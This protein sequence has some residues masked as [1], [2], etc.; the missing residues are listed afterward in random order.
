MPNLKNRSPEV[1]GDF[2]D[3]DE[4]AE[5][6]DVSPRTITRW[7]GMLNGL[8]HIRLGMRTLYSIA[9]VRGWLATK[10]RAITRRRASKQAA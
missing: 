4:I 2:V 5:I 6:F 3:R 10:E 1:F 8:P 9:S 7:A